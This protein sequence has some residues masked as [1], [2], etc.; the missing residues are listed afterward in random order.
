LAALS[1]AATLPAPRQGAAVHRPEA[2]LVP[3]AAGWRGA[4]RQTRCHRLARVRL[5]AL[6]GLLVSAAARGELQTRGLPPRAASP[7]TG[8]TA[9]RLRQRHS[10]C[11][12]RTAR[13]PGRR[14][15][16]TSPPP[17]GML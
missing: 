10:R 2:G 16:A 13:S 9:S 4:P 17:L 7:R 1:P 6:G 8:S 5:L 3:A 14:P 12:D 11:C 15:W